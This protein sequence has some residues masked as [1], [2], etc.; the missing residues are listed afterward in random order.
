V[1]GSATRNFLEGAVTGEQ[2]RAGHARANR[3]LIWLTITGGLGGCSDW[4]AAPGPVE[5]QR[6]AVTNNYTFQPLGLLPG[7]GPT[8]ATDINNAGVIVGWGQSHEPV[9]EERGFKYDDGELAVLPL[10]RAYAIND[11][12]WVAGS[13]HGSAALLSPDGEIT[14]L[15]LA[16]GPVAGVAYDINQNGVVVGKTMGTDGHWEATRW[17]PHDGMYFGQSLELVPAVESQATALND[18]GEIVGSVTRAVDRSGH[19]RREAWNWHAGPLGESL[20]LVADGDDAVATAV[21]AGGLFSPQGLV[22]GY[23]N[24]VPDGSV[25]AFVRLPGSLGLAEL[26]LSGAWSVLTD[27]S[28]RGRLVG[29]Y[30]NSQAGSSL[31]Y[32][33]GTS[34]VVPFKTK[35]FT[36]MAGKTVVLYHVML[37]P[38]D[39]GGASAVNACGTIVGHVASELMVQAVRWT[40][41]QCDP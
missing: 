31:P 8:K 41:P 6:I 27:V 23:G 9:I 7:D 22:V 39:G 36:R 30:T 1:K 32:D 3:L 10:S 19:T 17:T 24:T 33:E 13:F 15:T 12:G 25:H 34:E 5:E 20:G 14:E 29:W 35:P 2:T 38:H 4:P 37:S 11:S 16:D 28:D 21:N 26:A 40:K 18:A